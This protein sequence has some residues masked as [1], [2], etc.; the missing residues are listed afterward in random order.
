MGIDLHRANIL[1]E[2]LYK[3]LM[4]SPKFKNRISVLDRSLAYIFYLKG[5]SDA[6]SAGE[7]LA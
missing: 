3:E 4:Q 6:S 2:E 1:F 7:V 5:Y